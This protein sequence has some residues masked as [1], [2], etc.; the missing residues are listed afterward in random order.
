MFC[1]RGGQDWKSNQAKMSGIILPFRAKVV[2]IL[3]MAYKH[4]S[5][6]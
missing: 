4:R 2:D 3:C 1:I 6:C 5:N